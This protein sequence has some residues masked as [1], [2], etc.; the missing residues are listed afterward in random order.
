MA[1]RECPV[2]KNKLLPGEEKCTRCGIDVR[3]ID[4][5]FAPF[6]TPKSCILLRVLSWIPICAAVF[7]LV[8]MCSVGSYAE[9]NAF[10]VVAYIIATLT[11]FA[12]AGGLRSMAVRRKIRA[13]Q[14]W[15]QERA[16]EEDRRIKEIDRRAA[17]YRAEQRAR[18]E[19][20]E[21]AKHQRE[22][23]MAAAAVIREEDWQNEVADE[24]RRQ[25]AQMRQTEEK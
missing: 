11:A 14:E 20:A 19:A 5:Y 17:E 21:R 3:P 2:C 9:I 15:E 12:V 10:G 25:R 18:A 7:F 8:Q 1:V 16:K 4:A 24:V 6:K 13:E 22:V 23:R